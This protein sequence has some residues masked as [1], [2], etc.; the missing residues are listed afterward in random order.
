MA[1]EMM[2]CETCRSVVIYPDEIVIGHYEPKAN[3][4]EAG[5]EFIVCEEKHEL[6]DKV[7]C[8]DCAPCECGDHERFAP[9]RAENIVVGGV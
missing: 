4:E 7:Y 3:P 5:L 8:L 6:D 1:Y 2:A 9:H